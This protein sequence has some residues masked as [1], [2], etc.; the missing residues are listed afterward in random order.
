MSIGPEIIFT[1]YLAY[2][3]VSQ[4]IFQLV[5]TAT[6]LKEMFTMGG[7]QDQLQQWQW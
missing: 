7:D 5:I 6:N 3:N 2:P 4:I 1:R